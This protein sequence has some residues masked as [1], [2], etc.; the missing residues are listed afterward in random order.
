LLLKQTSP[1][2]SRKSPSTA[3][4]A[5]RSGLDRGRLRRLSFILL[6]FRLSQK[7]PKTARYWSRCPW[8][9][10]GPRPPSKPRTAAHRAEQGVIPRRLPQFSRGRRYR[11]RTF[12]V[13]YIGDHNA[14]GSAY[15]ILQGTLWNGGTFLSQD[16]FTKTPATAPCRIVDQ[17][18]TARRFMSQREYKC[19]ESCRT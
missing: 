3:R 15:G 8:P 16:D 2:I 1:L 11:D 10:W 9:G 12:L 7:P 4:T 14:R 18:D 6:F 19:R 17:L 13:L 5:G